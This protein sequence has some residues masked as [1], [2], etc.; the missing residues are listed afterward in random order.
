[1]QHKIYTI[2]KNYFPALYEEVKLEMLQFEKDWTGRKSERAPAPNGPRFY[3][4]A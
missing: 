1:M 3:G 4:P 2:N